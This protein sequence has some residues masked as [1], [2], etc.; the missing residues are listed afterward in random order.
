MGISHDVRVTGKG[1][2]SCPKQDPE[3]RGKLFHSCRGKKKMRIYE[4]I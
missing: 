3:G 1:K 2:Y 4:T